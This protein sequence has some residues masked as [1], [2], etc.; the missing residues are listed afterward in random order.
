MPL[1]TSLM[2]YVVLSQDGTL[3]LADLID[4]FQEPEVQ[5]V[6][7]AYE[8]SV[9]VD[10]HCAPEGEWSTARLR[11]SVPFSLLTFYVGFMLTTA[12]IKHYKPSTKVFC[13]FPQSSHF[14]L[15]KP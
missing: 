7:R 3:S 10:I 5:R 8:N 1:D 14:N 6:L 11:R 15:F 13:N 2:V 9:T 4:A 12:T